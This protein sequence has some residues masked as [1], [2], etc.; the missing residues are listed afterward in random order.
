MSLPSSNPFANLRYDAPA[1]L[2][3]FLVALP[4]CLG[5]ALASAGE[6]H[7]F[8]G[9]IAGIVGGIVVGLISGS[10]L[11]V[12]GPAAGLTV[13]V[14]TAIQQL[15]SFEAF[16]LAVFLSGI[17]QVILGISRAGVVGDFIPSAVIKGMLA[18]I[19]LIL[20]LKQLPHAVG[21]DKDYEGD[22]SFFQPDGDNTF[23]ALLHMIDQQVT[24][25]ALLIALV[26]LAFLFWWDAAAFRKKG[27]LRFVPGPLVVVIF[28]VLANE[29]FKVSFPGL[30][31]GP[32]HLVAI[33]VPESVSELMGQIH[34]PDF[35]MIS[36]T[37]VW[38]TAV[39]LSL[40]ASIETLLS[41]EA[42]D[43]L[44]PL[45]R[46]T[47]TNRELI[48]QGVGNMTSGFLGGL[49]VTS[50]IVRSSANVDSGARTKASAI[51]HGVLLLVCVLAIPALLNKIPL[52][53]L[54]A[55]LIVLGYKLT[56]PQIFIKMFK[57]GWSHFLP[58]VITILA[59]LLT[60]LLIGIGIG[61][62]VGVFFIMRNNFKSAILYVADG[63]KHLIRFKKDLFFIHKL[64]L[65]AVLDKIPPDSEVLMDFSRANF[66][67]LDNVETINDYIETAPLKNIVV[68]VKRL[69]GQVTAIVDYQPVKT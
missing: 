43:K 50:V 47:P 37:N 56:K 4:L 54:A 35:G 25:G 30:A 10:P 52:S 44:D 6:A 24:W 9:I 2:V 49:P 46:N 53:A 66:I 3:V 22:F 62:A 40:V 11:S 13:I 18:A 5:V 58:F 34:M 29:W 69:E 36:N 7:I 45:K 51:G 15:P 59:I 33:P 31:I 57:K 17:F 38:A 48:A 61:L 68:I 20:I 16:L 8:S 67:D 41:I 23:T 26:S 63:S 14:A 60:D 19:G 21:Y 55:I 28:S 42:V 32:E 64:E 65:R 1:A 12:S 27:A 39:T